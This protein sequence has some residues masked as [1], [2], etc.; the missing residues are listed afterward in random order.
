MLPCGTDERRTT[1]NDDERTREDKATQPL[2]AGRLSFA[3]SE[4]N[5]TKEVNL[6]KQVN[7]YLSLFAFATGSHLLEGHLN[8]RNMKRHQI[9]TTVRTA[10]WT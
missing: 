6:E 5:D 7:L 3:N 4:T 9:Q 10:S 1:T 8:I 2:D